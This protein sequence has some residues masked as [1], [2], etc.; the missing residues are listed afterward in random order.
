M[1][2][3]ISGV[4]TDLA[5]DIGYDSETIKYANTLFNN[6]FNNLNDI[7]TNNFNKQER[8]IFVAALYIAA[9]LKR[10]EVIDIAKILSIYEISDR[11]L[12]KYKIKVLNANNISYYSSPYLETKKV[13]KIP[14][15][16]S[17]FDDF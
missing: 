2:L 16:P 11:T 14:K 6:T 1:I 8:P 4:L 15:Q 3:M 5:R 12:L 7:V 9:R 10:D 17:F 13:P